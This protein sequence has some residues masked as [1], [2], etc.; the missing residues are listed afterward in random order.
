MPLH[1]TEIKLGLERD[2]EKTL[3]V[4]QVLGDLWYGFLDYGCCQS[5]ILI[6]AAI[7]TLE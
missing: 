4:K 6:H 3:T 5:T 7:R 2:K 1:L